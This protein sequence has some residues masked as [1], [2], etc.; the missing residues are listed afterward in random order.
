MKVLLVEDEVKTVRSVKMGLEEHHVDVDFAIDAETGLDLVR[1]NHYDVIVSDIILPG[2]S[3]LEFVSQLRH[4][5]VRSPVL[6]LTALGDTD[7]KVQ[8]FEAGADDYL[9]KP[10]EFRELLA[11]IR[12]LAR[13]HAGD[14][15]A[16]RRLTFADIVLDLDARTCSRQDK[17][18]ELTPKEFALMEY[19]IRHQGRVVSKR[20]IAEKVW[21]IHFDTGTNV[22]E[23]YVNY[24]RNKMDRPFENRLIQTVFGVGYVLRD[25]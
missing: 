6:M 14:S 18:I 19:F 20:E 8:G 25:S 15:V 17:P 21:D 5:G 4:E 23:V 10:F 11:R 9:P 16:R 7:D 1:K 3:G 13:R 12:A 24:L 2:T 22:V